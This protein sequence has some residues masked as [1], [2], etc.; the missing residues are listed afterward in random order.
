MENNTIQEAEIIIETPNN[1]D[2]INRLNT[3]TETKTP[4]ANTTSKSWSF[5]LDEN[6]TKA[7]TTT[8]PE[9]KAE[10]EVKTSD[11]ETT[12]APPASSTT[13]TTPPAS[14]EPKLSKDFKIASARITV[15]ALDMT[16]RM[17]FT[18]LINRKYS[19]KF[20]EQESKILDE[21][22]IIDEEKS[23]LNAQDLPLR[24]KFDRI[25]KKRDKKIKDIPF[26]DLESQDLEKMFY[27]YMDAKN[28]T[29]P[30]EIMLVI[31]IANVLGKRAIDLFTE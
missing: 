2:L 24:N 14:T 31:G 16:Q 15:S 28:T 4:T 12:Q 3:A 5:T 6:E 18:P 11:F 13:S 29:L 1:D 17:I 22:N 7:E 20:T 30:P 8:N 10:T 19:K 26:E 23:L 27:Q 25:M 21:T 9:T